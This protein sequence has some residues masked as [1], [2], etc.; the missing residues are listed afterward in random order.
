VKLARTIL[1]GAAAVAALSSACAAFADPAPAWVLG[2]YRGVSPKYHLR[3][4]LHIHRDGNV[5]IAIWKPG[6]GRDERDGM[7]MGHHIQFGKDKYHVER[8]PNGIRLVK[9]SDRSDVTIFHHP[10]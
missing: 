2:D 7:W 8:I 5:H 6:G 3:E 9:E 1:A 10:Q 4:D